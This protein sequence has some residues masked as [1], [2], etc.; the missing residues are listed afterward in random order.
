[1]GRLLEATENIL[2]RSGVFLAQVSG[3]PREFFTA[4]RSPKF[5]PNS[6]DFRTASLLL[7]RARATRWLRH[8]LNMRTRARRTPS[9]RLARTRGGTRRTKE[10]GA[11]SARRLTRERTRAVAQRYLHL[12]TAQLTR[13]QSQ[14]G[15]ALIPRIV[16]TALMRASHMQHTHACGPSKT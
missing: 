1:M 14:R 8:T 12:C 10:V 15:H 6:D 11:W 9:R 13:W 5:R 3:A 16:Y 2:A 4:S 7:K